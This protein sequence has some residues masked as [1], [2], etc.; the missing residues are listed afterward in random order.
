MYI[1]NAIVETDSADSAILPRIDVGAHEPDP[2]CASPAEAPVAVLPAR[3][4][5]GAIFE[6][7]PA[8]VI[9]LDSQGQVVRCNPAA[10]TLLGEPL[11]HEAWRAVISRA[12]DVEQVLRPTRASIGDVSEDLDP[13]P[14]GSRRRVQPRRAGQAFEESA[15]RDAAE[16]PTEPLAENAQAAPGLGRTLHPRGP[17]R[18]RFLARRP[19]RL[20]LRFFF[21]FFHDGSSS[22]APP[23]LNLRS[24]GS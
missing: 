21:F 8:G 14:L 20:P 11:L 13:M 15:G 16:A 17:Q 2:R 23:S 10:V 19:R 9:V 12:I 3:A 18:L 1:S 6:A 7:L 5:W 24:S 22:S 4:P